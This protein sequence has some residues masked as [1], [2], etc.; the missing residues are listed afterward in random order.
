M[1]KTTTTYRSNNPE[2]PQPGGDMGRWET[3]ED[4]NTLSITGSSEGEGGSG[5]SYFWLTA[6]GP[7][8]YALFDPNG[9]KGFAQNPTFKERFESGEIRVIHYW[10]E[11][12]FGKIPRGDRI[13][14]ALATMEKF[15]EDW[16]SAMGWARTVVWD[17]EDMVWEM[18]RYAHNEVDSPTPK[19]FHELNAMYAGWFS[20]AERHGVNFGLIR[21]LSEVWGKTGVNKQGKAT[22]GFT[23]EVKPRG[24]KQVREL[25]QINL[26]H[27]W[28]DDER[29][30]KVKIL[31]KCRIGDAVELLGKEFSNLDFLSLALQLYP[32]TD[33]GDWG[34]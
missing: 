11:L 33:P 20:D 12:N 32:D 23:G 10:K 1:K 24:Q 31:E 28:D 19:N 30:F 26:S 3:V 25:A 21:G 34:I 17:K 18:L 6:P 4:T 9:L 14:R 7:I 22:Y 29:T 13:E 2:D 15:G 8:A 27:R 5:K 16:D